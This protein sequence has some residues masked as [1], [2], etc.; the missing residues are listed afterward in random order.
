MSEKRLQKLRLTKKFKSLK[1]T[2][3]PQSKKSHKEKL[4]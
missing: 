4:R 1:K 2:S 3:K